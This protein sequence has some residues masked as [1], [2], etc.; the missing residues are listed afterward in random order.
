MMT[1]MYVI[2]VRDKFEVVKNE[3]VSKNYMLV[4]MLILGMII[5]QIDR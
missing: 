2:G 4:Q 5:R 3:Q 1:K